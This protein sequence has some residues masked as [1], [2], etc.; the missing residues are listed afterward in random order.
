[1][2][3]PQST[4]G[5]VKPAVVDVTFVG[6][7][8][9]ADFGRAFGRDFLDTLLRPGPDDGRVEVRGRNLIEFVEMKGG[10]ARTDPVV[11]Y[12]LVHGRLN[13]V[14]L[15][16][17][18]TTLVYGPASLDSLS[19][20]FLN[21]G[22]CEAVTDAEKADMR[23][24]FCDRTADAYGYAVADAVNTLLTFEQMGARDA[25]IYHAFDFGPFE[26]PPLRATLGSR[27]SNFLTRTASRKTTGS[28][29]LRSFRAL[30]SLMRMGGL[31]LFRRHPD[32]SKYGP[33]TGSTHG[34]LLFSRSPTK[35][36]HE[37][38][39]M[40]RDVDMA[41]CYNAII[42]RLNVYCGRPIIG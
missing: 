16:M 28:A 2:L 5:E 14:R 27:V 12:A 35:F 36:W 40:L 19:K 26:V 20:T 22:K 39:G 3:A 37:S 9:R 34:G 18:D 41:G 33:Q 31:D 30:E 29:S 23:K 7:F 10:H 1:M 6:H 38:R 32:A 13:E 15:R 25:A 42:S 11:E 8:L 4:G 17:R 24:V 21:L